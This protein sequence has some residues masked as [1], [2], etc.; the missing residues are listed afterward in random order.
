MV[1][2]KSLQKIPKET[3]SGALL[4]IACVQD[5][6][7]CPVIKL[8]RDDAPL[9]AVVQGAGAETTVP[10]GDLMK[11]GFSSVSILLSVQVQ[12]G[13]VGPASLRG[14]TLRKPSW[15]ALFFLSMKAL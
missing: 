12:C 4:I 9:D 6:A 14:A 3:C 11:G 1:S 10:T 15:F 5:S 2:F 7:L 13:G 8:Q